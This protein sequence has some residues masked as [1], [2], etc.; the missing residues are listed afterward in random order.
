[1]TTTVN[2]TKAALDSLPLPPAGQRATYHDSKQPG[3]QVRVTANGV[4]TFSVFARAAGEVNAAEVRSG[5]V[6]RLARAAKARL[7]L[8]NEV[9]Q[10]ALPGCAA[11]PA[12]CVFAGRLPVTCRFVALNRRQEKTERLARFF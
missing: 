5:A 8:R 2:F 1:M 10:P 4:K 9:Q 7:A 3:L 6:S 12:R 11:G